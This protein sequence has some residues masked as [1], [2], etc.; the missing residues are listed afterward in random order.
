MGMKE[1]KRKG[2]KEGERK[3]KDKRRKE[4]RDRTTKNDV[5]VFDI[6][7]S[8]FVKRCPRLSLLQ[9]PVT[10]YNWIPLLQLH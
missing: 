9:P 4:R 10:V 8:Y 6:R 2:K 5:I 3:R 1:E 7:L